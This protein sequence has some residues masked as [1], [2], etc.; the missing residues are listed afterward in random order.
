MAVEKNKLEEEAR[1]LRFYKIVLSWDYFRILKEF[2]VFVSC[3]SFY[4]S[5]AFLLLDYY[6]HYLLF[7]CL[8]NYSLINY[9]IH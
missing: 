9:L 4:F 8:N 3:S 7:L 1:V 2:M 5:S 6:M